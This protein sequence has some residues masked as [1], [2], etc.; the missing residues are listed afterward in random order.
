L[1]IT[2]GLQVTITDQ[3]GETV[4]IGHLQPADPFIVPAQ[5]TGDELT[6]AL[7]T[8]DCQFQFSADLSS[9]EVTFYK[10]T[11]GTREGPTYSRSELETMDWKVSIALPAVL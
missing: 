3:S 4:G 2:T 11:V 1:D 8:Q 9:T 10:I 5:K 6:D 7:H